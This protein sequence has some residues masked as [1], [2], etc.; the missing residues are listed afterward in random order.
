MTQAIYKI[1]NHGDLKSVGKV[2][3]SYHYD[4]VEQ[5]AGLFLGDDSRKYILHTQRLGHAEVREGWSWTYNSVIVYA[6]DTP[7]A[8]ESVL[9]L[10]CIGGVDAL[11]GYCFAV[12]DGLGGSGLVGIFDS[13]EKLEQYLASV[14]QEEAEDLF[15]RIVPLNEAL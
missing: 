11:P 3:K 13:R 10:M 6:A 2:F 7:N 15:I 4:T 12:H 1:N 8:H 9:R 14:S 5:C